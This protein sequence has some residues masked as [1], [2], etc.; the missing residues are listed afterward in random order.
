MGWQPA[1]DE[2]KPEFNFFALD[3]WRILEAVHNSVDAARVS[4]EE[5]VEKVVGLVAGELPNAE[6]C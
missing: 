5:V 3:R 2:C 1:V 6:F 4:N